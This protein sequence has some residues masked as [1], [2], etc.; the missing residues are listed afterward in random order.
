MHQ[1]TIN[2]IGD[3][4]ISITVILLI[5]LLPAMTATYRVSPMWLVKLTAW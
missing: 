5:L 4:T 3:S 2:V 1:R